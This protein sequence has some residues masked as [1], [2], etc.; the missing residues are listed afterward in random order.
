MPRPRSKPPE[1]QPAVVASKKPRTSASPS[2]KPSSLKKNRGC[3]RIDGGPRPVKRTW[4]TLKGGWVPHDTRD[5]VIDFLNHWI[6]RSEL[7]AKRLLGW[8]ELGTSKFY[9]WRR[10]YGKVNEHNALVPRDDWLAA[11]EKQAIVDF[12]DSHPLEGYRRLTF[13]MLDA[14][15]VA[16]SPSSTY[17]VL[18]QA[19]RL[20]RHWQKPSKKGSGFVQPLVAHEH[21]HVDMS[22]I[23]VA[24]TFYYLTS[25]LDGYSRAIVHAEVRESMTER[26]VETVVQR[27]REK[28]PRAPAPAG[29]HPR[30]IS[31]NGP[32]F[33]AREFKEFIRIAGMTHVRTSPYYPQ[34][35][36]KLERWHASLKCECIRPA[37]PQSADEARRRVAAYVEYYNNVRLHGAIGYV[38]PLD[39][40]AGRERA[41]W[42][43][44]DA[45]LAAARE[46]RAAARHAERSIA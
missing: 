25:I 21:W 34:S 31:D 23:N 10:R 26:D 4:G 3:G 9:D 28:Y 33:I 36:G 1:A 45:R 24:G 8:L 32:Q 19:G 17:R 30:I 18:R 12:H 38:T 2:S 43:A 22:Y 41:I 7:P 40:L 35:N 5:E 20:D 11:W 13:M 14:D 29:R 44:R 27:A 46:R 6:E 42:E 15:V 16:V 37:A 39:K